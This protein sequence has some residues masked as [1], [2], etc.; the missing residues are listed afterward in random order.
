LRKVVLA[1]GI[2]LLLS[3]IILTSFSQSAVELP[4]EKIQEKVEEKIWREPDPAGYYSV[5]PFYLTNGTAFTISFAPLSLPPNIPI[6]GI[7]VYTNITD[8]LGEVTK[9][10]VFIAS[11][12]ET[13]GTP[14]TIPGDWNGT[15]V[16]NST[17]EYKLCIF[18]GV[19]DFARLTVLAAYVKEG[20]IRHPYSFFSYVGIIVLGSGLVL[21]FF[22][23]LSSKTKKK[24]RERKRTIRKISLRR[25]NL[26]F[27]LR[28]NPYD[29]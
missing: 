3:G 13:G 23:G 14:L 16:A 22:G 11:G 19:I 24:S 17:G 4:P 5:P 20:E 27:C 21:S 26:T 18:S 25:D 15:A 10:Y 8:P 29:F 1:F 2:L 7:L 6:D 12:E 28:L 9:K